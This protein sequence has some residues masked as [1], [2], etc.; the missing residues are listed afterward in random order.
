MQYGATCS[1]TDGYDCY[2]NALAERVNGILKNELLEHPP[3][4]LGQARRMVREAVDIYNRERPHLALKY[5][6]PD[7]V[8]RAL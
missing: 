5:K 4:D 3:A 7:A 2:Q 1:I 8:H 6:T